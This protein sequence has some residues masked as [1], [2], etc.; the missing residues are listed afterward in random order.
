[1]FFILNKVTY[2][3]AFPD[4]KNPTN[5]FE[6]IFVFDQNGINNKRVS[7][8]IIDFIGDISGVYD[9]MIM[10]FGFF[11]NSIS[12]HSFTLKAIKK[13]FLVKTDDF[14]LLDQKKK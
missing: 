4:I 6:N 3:K 1:M 12:Y 5:V 2:V 14:H 7:Y 10:T 11:I 9:L 8:N 13:L